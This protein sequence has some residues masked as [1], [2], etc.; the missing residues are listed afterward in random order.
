ML[1]ALAPLLRAHPELTV[2]LEFDVPSVLERRLV[3]GVLDLVLLAQPAELAGVVTRPIASETFVANAPAAVVEQE[4]ARL[5]D[6]T[7][8]LDGLRS[9]RAK[10]G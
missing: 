2:R 10:L 5:G 8:Q 6:W 9:Q 1:L 4:R 7:M 3:D